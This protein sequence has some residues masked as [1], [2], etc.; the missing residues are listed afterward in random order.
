MA[1]IHAFQ[2]LASGLFQQ[3]DVGMR[4][5]GSQSHRP[6]L[7]CSDCKWTAKPRAFRFLLQLFT[8]LTR[9]SFVYVQQNSLPK[10]VLQCIQQTLR[11]SSYTASISIS[12]A[13]QY[14]ILGFCRFKIYIFVYG[15]RL[16][17]TAYNYYS[18]VFII[19]VNNY[20]IYNYEIYNHVMPI[21]S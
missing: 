14:C 5:G 10:R 13:T 4:R 16:V 19:V 8:R 20:V 9:S 11:Q 18:L 2:G 12:C 21:V 7:R 15:R 17:E 3:N 1:S 6:T